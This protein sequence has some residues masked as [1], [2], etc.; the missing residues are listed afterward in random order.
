M[1]RPPYVY[2]CYI[3]LIIGLSACAPQSASAQ[4]TLRK[5]T[6]ER[7][8]VDQIVSATGAVW[9]EERNNLS[10]EQSGYVTDVYVKVGSVVKAGDMLARINGRTLDLAVTQAELRLQAQEAAYAK[11]F[12]PPSKAQVAGAQAAVAG[13]AAGYDK[14]ASPP[15]TEE[16]LVAQMQYEQ[17]YAAYQKADIQL[18]AVQWYAPDFITDQYRAQFGATVANLETARLRLEQLT[19]PP[20]KNA[21]AAASASVAQAQA[22]LNAL[23]EG[24]DAV[25][26]ARAQNLIHQAQ[27]A[28]ERA[29]RQ[30]DGAVLI[31]PFSGV[32]SVVNVNPGALAPTNLPAIVLV[33]LS[34][35]HIEV[36]VD[37]VDIGKVAVGQ[38]A[39]IQFDALPDQS[40]QG[41]VT[42]IAPLATNSVGVV[43][44]S[45]R[46]DLAL[47]DLPIRPGM[48]ATADIVIQRTD[49]V[50]LVPNWAIRFD[51]TTGQAYASILN[52]DGKLQ[53]VPVLLG[54]R[55]GSQ[56]QVVAGLR[57]GQVVAV[58]LGRQGFSLNGGN[59]QGGGQ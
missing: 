25:S 34:R 6:V 13:A 56:S 19:K 42:R 50:L 15:D 48:T 22:Q 51:R 21:L 49:N 39:E 28:L 47:F 4:A 23:R 8:T 2:I 27:L 32:V 58:D 20:D 33:D 54:I 59:N 9:P 26:V 45:V 41:Q 3:G 44:Y 5:G 36:N 14:A 1:R 57:E 11:L 29:R 30:R 17:A 43:T 35:L 38:P 52:A 31:A 18:R 55:S 16:L 37:E 7:G 10:F 46:I 53:E 12:E 40:V 24:P